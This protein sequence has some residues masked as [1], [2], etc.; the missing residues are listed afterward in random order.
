MIVNKYL[1]IK[2]KFALKIK[3]ERLKEVI[4]INVNYIDHTDKVEK[5]ISE[6]KIGPRDVCSFYEPRD[7]C[8]VVMKECWYCRYADFQLDKP[9]TLEFGICCY[10]NKVIK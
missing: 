6:I 3:L 10:P 8:I 4:K 7:K 5:R 2:S 1:T 9:N